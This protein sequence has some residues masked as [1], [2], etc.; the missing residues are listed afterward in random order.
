MV[1]KDKYVYI[2][3]TNKLTENFFFSNNEYFFFSGN[4]LSRYKQLLYKMK[5]Y[6]HYQQFFKEKIVQK[7]NKI[8]EQFK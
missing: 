2:Y 8:I 5:L 7:I 6:F 3:Y 4:E 1:Y